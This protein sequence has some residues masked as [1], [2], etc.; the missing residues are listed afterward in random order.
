MRCV[1]EESGPDHEGFPQ[2][3]ARILRGAE[4]AEY[5]AAWKGR[6]AY[7]SPLQCQVLATALRKTRLCHYQGESVCPEDR[8]W[9]LA[10][11]EQWPVMPVRRERYVD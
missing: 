6:H 10:T 3:R 9:V 11:L 2:Y 7:M 4:L 1:Y 8:D 5:R